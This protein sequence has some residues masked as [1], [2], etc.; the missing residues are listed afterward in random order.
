MVTKP[1]PGPW[2]LCYDDP[3]K[4]NEY[5]V[6]ALTDDTCGIVCQGTYADIDLIVTACNAA[7]IANPSN[8]IAAAEALPELKAIIDRL[9][10]WWDEN[11]GLTGP[12]AGSMFDESRT[13]NDVIHAA[14]ARAEGREP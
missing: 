14:I 12:H 4:P 11:D 3:T 1:T 6:N 8:P 10:G 7:Q 2:R 13:W 5:A 9:I